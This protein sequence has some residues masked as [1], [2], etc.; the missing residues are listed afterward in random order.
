[1]TLLLLLGCGDGSLDVGDAVDIAAGAFERAGSAHQVYRVSLAHPER[2]EHTWGRPV[3]AGRDL[4]AWLADCPV[5]SGTEVQARLRLEAG[6]FPW[7]VR[8]D[9]V[10]A[11]L[12]PCLEARLGQLP[13]EEP[14]RAGETDLVFVRWTV[15]AP[16]G[17]FGAA[18][19]LDPRGGRPLPALPAGPAFVVVE[20]DIPA[21]EAEEGRLR[22][23]TEADRWATGALRDPEALARL[24]TCEA[25]GQAMTRLVVWVRDGEI[26]RVLTDPEVDCVEEAVRRSRDRVLALGLG[27]PSAGAAAVP[28]RLA[29]ADAALV[30]LD[31]PLGG[32]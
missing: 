11:A 20:G 19:G 14:I 17:P 22:F 24:A 8:V 21:V 12:E 5:P 25:P 1:M 15:D 10:D 27:A 18:R 16:E 13:F 9:G 32:W 29:D 6:G 26:E 3:A 2:R 30:R 4:R 23:R 31:V 28:D 7:S